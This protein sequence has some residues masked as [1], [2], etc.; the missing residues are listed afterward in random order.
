[1]IMITKMKIMIILLMIQSI[2]DD[3]NDHNTQMNGVLG[4]DSVKA[5]LD[6]RQP[7]RMR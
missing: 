2:N 6:W 1:M 5:I 4:H 7:G 3:N